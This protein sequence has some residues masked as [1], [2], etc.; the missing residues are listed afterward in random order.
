MQVQDKEQ[1]AEV[2]RARGRRRR[3]GCWALGGDGFVE[4]ERRA[5]IC[6]Q[7]TGAGPAQ[8]QVVFKAGSRS[9][10]PLRGVHG[11]GREHC[12]A[13]KDFSGD[14]GFLIQL[15]LIIP[16][17]EADSFPLCF[18]FCRNLV[19]DKLSCFLETVTVK[20]V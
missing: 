12:E 11:C 13:P 9:F 4:Q 1:H 20:A 8:G 17:S 16:C 2:Q 7:A 18:K 14:L 15:W 5:A 6:L 10:E 19:Y 3:G